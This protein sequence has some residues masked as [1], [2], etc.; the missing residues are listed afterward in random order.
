MSRSLLGVFALALASLALAGQ[1]GATAT[2]RMGIQDDA[3]LRW[4][5]GT[6]ESRLD[7]LD[8][9]GVKTVRFTLLWNEVATKKPANAANPNDPAY[10]W[11]QFD[12]VL[13]GLRAHGITPLVTLYGSPTWANGGRAPNYLPTSG[14][15][16]FAYAASKHYSWIRLWTVWNEPNTRVFSVPVSPKLYTQ[17]LLNNAYVWLHKANHANVVAGGVTSP[18]KTAS[19]MSPT[20]FMLGMRAAHAKLDAYAANPYAA[21]KVETPTYDPCAHCDTLTMAHLS[22]IRALVTRLFGARKPL[23][24]TEYGYQTNPPDRL[25]GV[26]PARQAALIGQAALRVWQAPGV[27][28]LIQF[29]VQDEPELGGWQSGLL[30]ATGK[31]KP[32]YRAFA[33]PLAEL[34]RH[35]TRTVLWGQ[36][37]PGSGRR[38][39][40]I[41]RWTG[42]RWVN[43]GSVKRTGT[44][45]T[46][47]TVVALRTGTKVRLRATQ[48]SFASPLLAIA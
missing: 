32:S 23:W 13:D 5:P 45:G 36:V 2:A 16:Q 4:G 44:G 38:P 40:V 26:S 17:R 37:R 30:T 41:Q 28:V 47:R 42:S 18:R 8:T 21:S 43:V 14:F 39:Y 29:L 31:Q 12:P 7:T 19:G 11:T 22:T 1:A 6:L 3:W 25:L 46:F 34:S 27:T 9:L 24:L 33:L 15:G 10:D 48:V 35:G 20:T